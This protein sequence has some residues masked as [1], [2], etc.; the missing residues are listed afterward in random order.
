[1]A[2]ITR[3]LAAVLASFAIGLPACA[4][5]SHA[6]PSP[7]LGHVVEAPRHVYRLDYALKASDGTSS[8]VSR[9]SVGLEEGHSGELRT[10]VNMV[11]PRPPTEPLGSRGTA[12][13][14]VGFVLKSSYALAGSDL[15]L[16]CSAES[17]DVDEQG[18]RK[19]A[20]YGDVVVAPGTP[21]EVMRIDDPARRVSYLLEVTATKQR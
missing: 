15:V 10:G 12:R 13:Q 7:R 6:V 4:G 8:S 9:Y 20:S 21:T 3:I 18:I 5:P 19:L 2:S 16:H 1:M 14:D 11:I 17:S